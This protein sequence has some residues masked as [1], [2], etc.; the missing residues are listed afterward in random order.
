MLH[1]G[2]RDVRM[3]A[4]AIEF[5]FRM[6][7]M[8]VIVALGF[9]APWIEVWGLGSR[10]SLLEWLA[11]E[12][13]RVGLLRF[14]YAT[15]AVIVV[16]A[17]IAFI[18]AVFRVW[19]T[20]Y[21]GYGTVHHAAMQAGGVMADGPYRYVRN[22]LYIGGWCMLV[23]TALT[24]PSTGALFSIVLLTVF[25]LRLILGEEAFLSG[26]L[27]EPYREYLRAVPRLIP[28]LSSAPP[29]TGQKPHW[30]IA[31][32]SE[33]NPI[34]VFITVALL[35]WSYDNVLMLKGLLISFG[36]SLV[37]RAFF[38]RKKTEDLIGR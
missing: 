2:K 10:K 8:V 7:I 38:I 19:G 17:L 32:L 26:Q 1:S 29:S 27:G 6:E 24:M 31:V 20:A 11:L 33:V 35:S 25:F 23:A 5:R 15:P 14:G 12:L 13:S 16:G 4:S 21:L 37:M 18:G 28:R 3:K 36:L 34:G 30:M 9:W 22:P